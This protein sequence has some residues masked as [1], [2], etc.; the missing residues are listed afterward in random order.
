MDFIDKL[1]IVMQSHSDDAYS[2]AKR[3][4]VPYTEIAALFNRKWEKSPVWVVAA[5]CEAYS[6]SMDYMVR[7][8]P[9]R[10]KA[11]P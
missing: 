2:L 6:V 1:K 10:E 11:E 5:I 8:I 3:A 9:Q 4:G 7:D